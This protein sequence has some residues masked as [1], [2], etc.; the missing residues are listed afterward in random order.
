MTKKL[1]K[2]RR[3]ADF[4]PGQAHFN[5]VAAH[6]RP[7]RPYLSEFLMERSLLMF[8]LF[9][10]DAQQLDWLH[11]PPEDLADYQCCR[12]LQRQLKDI[13]V[14]NNAAER[15]VKAYRIPRR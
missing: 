2:L 9:S 10:I 12:D 7:D 14:V 5:P 13:Q 1:H 8:N 4:Q 6:L 3:P 11:T 15:L